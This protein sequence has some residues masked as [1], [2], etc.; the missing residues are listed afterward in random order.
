MRVLEPL[1][2]YRFQVSLSFPGEHRS[3]VAAV[4]D[5]LADKLGRE[6]VLY[7]EWYSG[8]FARPNLNVYLPKLYHEQS[9]LLVFFLC[10]AYVQ[11][12]W[13]GLEWRAGLD[14]LKK[15]Q[16]ERL[17]LLRL[18]SGE[19]PGLY[20]IDGYLDVSSR[21][22]SAVANEILKRLTGEV[23]KMVPG[24]R[25]QVRP[26]I[27][28]RCGTIRVL[29][30]EQPTEIGGIYTAVNV[31]ERRPGNL[32]KTRDEL[33]KEANKGAFD[34]FG[35]GNG[36]IKRIPGLEALMKHQ[37]IMIYGKPGAGKTTFLKRLAIECAN[38]T[39]RSELV[40]AFI[41]LKDFAEADG[42]P[43]MVSYIQQQWEEYP[44]S[45]AILREGRALI[46]LDGLDEVRD[47]EFARIRK[48]VEAFANT[49]HRCSMVLTCRIAAREYA[50]ER[51]TEVEMAD[52][53]KTQIGDFAN[54]W[55]DVQGEK[56]RARSFMAKLRANKA[57]F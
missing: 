30:M 8:E 50:F 43:T 38:G 22:D 35:I 18:D 44:N 48:A 45:Q 19:I 5:L 2:S 53:D 16:D 28:N 14:L 29:T 9:L 24:L 36:S 32:R 21:S 42:L 10:S 55:F 12:E 41:T 1:P 11:K 57:I 39:F 25:N 26:D 17:M 31:L 6:N 56:K 4:A 52:F 27:R 13:C 7:D 3:R 54:R 15:R 33:I 20:S 47:Q 46:L 34:R 51:F 37:R 23:D 49:F 40:P